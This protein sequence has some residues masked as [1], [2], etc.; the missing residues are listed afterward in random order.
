M[1]AVNLGSFL[2]TIMRMKMKNFL[3]SRKLA[4]AATV[5]SF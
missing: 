5:Q 4:S 2:T 1:I 3:N